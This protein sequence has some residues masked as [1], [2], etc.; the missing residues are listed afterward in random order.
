MWQRWLSVIS[1]LY[2]PLMSLGNQ[3]TVSWYHCHIFHWC[4][5]ETKQLSHDIIVMYSIDIT[6]KPN[7]CLMISLFY[8]PLISLGNQTTVSWYHCFIFHW[9]H[10]E[11]KQLS[12][13]FIVLYSIDITWKPNSCL[14]ISLFYI[15]LMSLGNQTTVSWYHCFIFHWCYMET[16]QL[17]HDIIVLYSVD[18]TWKPN[19]CFKISLQKFSHVVQTSMYLTWTWSPLWLQMSWHLS[20]AR[21]STK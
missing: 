21:T 8:I 11:T 3:T 7:N 15:P 20:S 6:W 1:L 10:L 16:K 18:V 5:T 2:I 17:S 13:D 19:K 9:Y 12:H 4:Y 14:M